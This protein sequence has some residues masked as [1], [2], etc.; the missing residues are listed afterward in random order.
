MKCWGSFFTPTTTNGIIIQRRNFLSYLRLVLL[1]VGLLV[2]VRVEAGPIFGARAGYILS[3]DVTT[4]QL[5]GIFPSGISDQGRIAFESYRI[6]VPEPNILALLGLAFA[7]ICC[8]QRK[9]IG[10]VCVSDG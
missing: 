4:G 9:R 8:H 2:F 10:S 5:A 3:F 6:P 7:G 1:L